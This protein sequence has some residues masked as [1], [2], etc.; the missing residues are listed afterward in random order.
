MAEKLALQV[1]SEVLNKLIDKEANFTINCGLS[2]LESFT[3]SQV[4]KI[5]CFKYQENTY[6]VE[7]TLESQND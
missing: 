1:R 6:I 3:K 7:F 2:N 5:D 4:S